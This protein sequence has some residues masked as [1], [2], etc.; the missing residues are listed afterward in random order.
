MVQVQI[1]FTGVNQWVSKLAHVATGLV[2]GARYAVGHSPGHPYA[3]F[4][5]G[6]HPA[7]I[8]TPKVKKALYWEGA[9]HPVGMVRHPGYRGNPYLTDALAAQQGEINRLFVSGLRGLIAGGPGSIR[10]WAEESADLVLQDAKG[11]ANRKTG[12][13]IADL[14][15]YKQ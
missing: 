2:G 9:A 15:S 5:H 10:K 3:R 13:L 8:I 7:H 1:R 14:H 12:N 11:R 4:V 6:G